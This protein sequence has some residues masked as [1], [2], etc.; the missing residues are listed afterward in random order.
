MKKILI[1][2]LLASIITSFALAHSGGTNSSGCH[3]DHK[4]GIYHCH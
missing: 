4:T 3:L 1:V 2:S